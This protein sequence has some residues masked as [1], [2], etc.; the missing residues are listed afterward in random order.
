MILKISDSEFEIF[1]LSL[2]FLD[3]NLVVL[4]FSFEE[5]IFVSQSGDFGGVLRI[6][7]GDGFVPFNFEGKLCDFLVVDLDKSIHL[8]VLFFDDSLNG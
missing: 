6:G 3:E 1:L 7:D 2:E 5:V 8:C 4:G